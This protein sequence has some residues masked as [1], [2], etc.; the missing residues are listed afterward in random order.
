MDIMIRNETEQDFRE[1]EEVT[2]E[3]FW[4][5]YVPGC[6]EHYLV[7]QMRNHPDFIKDLDFVAENNGKIVGNIMYTNAW[8]LN[9]QGQEKDIISFGPLSV[10][11]EYQRQGIGS[12]LIRHTI[13]IARQ[14]GIQVIVILG[15]PH[16][17][18]QHGFKSG[19]DLNIS[20]MNGEYPYGLLALEVEEEALEG[21]QWKFKYSDVFTIH[22]EEAECFDRTFESK[23]KG[24]QYSQ[25]IFSIAFRSYVK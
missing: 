23:Q 17:Y 6:T 25:D 2:R 19:K 3:A 18:C 13:Q 15:D 1:V 21:H 22:E 24:Y 7:H 10:L 20:D 9:E 12:A 14:Q 11:P 5:L 8:L 4:N 16:N